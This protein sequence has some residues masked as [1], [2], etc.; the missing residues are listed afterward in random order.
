MSP[1][2]RGDGRFGVY[3]NCVG[4]RSVHTP[5]QPV[6]RVLW[7]FGAIGVRAASAIYAALSQ[8]VTRHGSRSELC[9][10]GYLASVGPGEHRKQIAFARTS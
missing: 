4:R 5:D 6:P 8:S 7:A 1:P 9:C 10:R 3:A 2:R